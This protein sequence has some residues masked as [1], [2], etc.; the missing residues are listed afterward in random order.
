[1]ERIRPP[2]PLLAL[3]L[4]ALLQGVAWIVAMPAFQG[5]DEGR[6][7]AYVQRVADA[8]SIPWRRGGG[9][10][11]VR[12][13]STE[14]E[15]AAVWSGLGPAQG[16]LGAKPLWTTLDE[17]LWRA[18]D[19]SLGS[20]ARTDGGYADSFHN[21]P[22]YYLYV[23]IPWTVVHRAS[24]FTRVEAARLAGLPCLL[25]I[26]VLT[27]LIAGELLGPALLPRTLATA[28]VALHPQLGDMA[29]TVNP[30]IFL[31]ALSAAALL[32]M[33]R[34]LRRGPS[35]GRI[36]VLVALCAAAALTHGRGL[37]LLA[38]AGLALAFCWPWARRRA[39]WLAGAA[40]G[41]VAL[42]VLVAASQGTGTPRQ[43]AS[44]LWQFYLPRLP[45]MASPAIGPPGY[46]AR[47]AFVDRFFGTFAGL[48]VTFPP[49]ALDLLAVLSAVGLVALVVVLVRRRA[50]LRA[51]RAEVVVLAAAILAVLVVLHVSAYRALLANPADPIVTG[52]Y[53]LPLIALA[54][55]AVALVVRELP[56]RA[57][58]YVAGALIAGAVVAQLGALGLIVE[59][60]SA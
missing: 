44:Y 15:T 22:L 47:E 57:G 45:G 18:R 60:F 32:A 13:L 29:A 42:A 51:R 36:A 21:P 37:A 35:P 25:A 38:P 41:V 3:L 17:R 30:D 1:V 59:R 10:E 26:V 4:L 20:G 55:V 8:H 31:G 16:N 19:S 14:A 27:W 12:R 9:P 54:G 46:G 28:L 6:H 52:R 33:L 5:P 40:A 48:E 39:W 2:R 50:A 49:W 53:L 24:F 7:I 34:L 58:A 23:A 43:F 56:R 11:T